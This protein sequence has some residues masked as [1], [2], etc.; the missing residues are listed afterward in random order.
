MSI[1]S[2]F[3]ELNEAGITA[4]VID[5]N[6]LRAV[7]DGSLSNQSLLEDMSSLA[8]KSGYFVR[9]PG[10]N[11]LL[12]QQ[13]LRKWGGEGAVEI[14]HRPVFDNAFTNG[15]ERIF[16]R[17]EA[18]HLMHEGLARIR[19]A[20]GSDPAF[21]ESISDALYHL[22]YNILEDDQ[23]SL[24]NL[25]E[26]IGPV[27]KILVAAGASNKKYNNYYRRLPSSAVLLVM[28]A[29]SGIDSINSLMQGKLVYG[30]VAGALSVICGVIGLIRWRKK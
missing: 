28:A 11:E 26:L 13:C 25:R 12:V 2:L 8:R 10:A 16:L 18:A 1:R 9:I 7:L 4:V 17:A 14:Y 15:D 30:G 29:I 20:A 24:D 5:Q 19:G 27:R 3:N 21:V 23:R 22:P 6:C